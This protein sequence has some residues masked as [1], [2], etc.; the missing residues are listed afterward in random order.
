M[1]LT[2]EATLKF[3]K[4]TPYLFE[5]ICAVFPATL[6]QIVDEG[7]D[8]FEKYLSVIT[9]MKPSVAYDADEELK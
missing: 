5:D 2:D 8:E 1:N 7:Y 6:G 3:M 4:G 9:T